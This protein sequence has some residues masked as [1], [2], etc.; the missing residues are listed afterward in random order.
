MT[1]TFQPLAALIIL[2]EKY[3][4]EENRY[5]ILIISTNLYHTHTYTND[6]LGWMT[7]QRMH[8]K[9]FTVFFASV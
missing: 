7:L 5:L 2:I 3:L 1:Y 8:V 9:G 6:K 4:Q